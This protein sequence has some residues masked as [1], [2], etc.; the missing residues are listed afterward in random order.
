MLK[1]R[2]ASELD[3]VLEL[4]VARKGIGAPPLA[5]DINLCCCYSSSSSSFNVPV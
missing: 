4:T 3:G 1:K 5:L 2:I